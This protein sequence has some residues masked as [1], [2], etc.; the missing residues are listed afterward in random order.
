MK[1]KLGIYIISLGS[2]D[3]LNYF[4]RA[5]PRI[6][7]SMDHNLDAWKE[8]KKVSPTTFVIGRHYL[9]DDAQLFED[10][11]EGRAER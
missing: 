2:F 6:A 11:P 10:D 4:K 1:S 5:Q 3:A 7:V 8:I 9:D